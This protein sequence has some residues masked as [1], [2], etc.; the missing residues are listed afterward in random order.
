MPHVQE[1]FR[2]HVSAE[3]VVRADAVKALSRAAVAVHQDR[4]DVEAPVLLNVLR[5]VHADYYHSVKGPAFHN[6]NVALP[7]VGACDK[8]MVV[9]PAHLKLHRAQKSAVKGVAQHD[10]SV[11]CCVLC[12]W[13]HDP[14]HFRLCLSQHPARTQGLGDLAG[15]VLQLF[16]RRKHPV[17]CLR[18]NGD[19]FIIIQ[20]I[21]YGRWR[22]S[23]F[24][25]NV[26]YADFFHSPLIFR[27][28][29]FY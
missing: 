9:G 10:V 2:R 15:H 22:H 28:Y 21:G 3:P 14:D 23:R 16:R 26:F 11:R 24:L 8:N 5:R 4:G 20:D 29:C 12:L 1:I 19:V 6:L 7:P 27:T 18:R 13:D 17:P 25:C